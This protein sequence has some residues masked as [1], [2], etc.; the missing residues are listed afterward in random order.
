M[1]HEKHIN[2]QTE[3]TEI[4]YT[5]W[6]YISHIKIY[7]LYGKNQLTWIRTGFGQMFTYG[8]INRSANW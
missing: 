2:Q 5:V 7:K 6:I 1:A 4:G 8:L 3:D